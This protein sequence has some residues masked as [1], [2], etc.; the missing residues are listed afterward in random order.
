MAVTD[1]AAYILGQTLGF[2]EDMLAPC[3]QRGI[4]DVG[5]LIDSPRTNQ[6]QATPS[7]FGLVCRFFNRMSTSGRFVTTGRLRRFVRGWLTTS[8]T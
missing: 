2:F 4:A 8:C 6:L 5:H 3:V 7:V 1:F